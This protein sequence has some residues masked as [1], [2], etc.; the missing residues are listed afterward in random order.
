MLCVAR[1][2]SY[3]STRIILN[4]FLAGDRI[5]SI[6]FSVNIDASVG[7]VV[8]QLKIPHILRGG[9]VFNKNVADE[10]GAHS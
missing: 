5:I 4:E 7:L 3:F 1:R 9:G 6:A 8:G 10:A 2:T